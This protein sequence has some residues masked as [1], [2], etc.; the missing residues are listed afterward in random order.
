MNDLLNDIIGYI[1]LFGIIGSYI[2]QY[3]KIV[4]KKS[5]NGIS[6]KFLFIGYIGSIASFNNA[7]IFYFPEWKECHGFWDCDTRTLGFSQLLFQCICFFI[8]Y[9][10][11]MLYF[12]DIEL[13]ICEP[14]G[15]CCS[16]KLVAWIL[17]LI[18]NLF[19]ISLSITTFEL[20]LHDLINI[21]T[22]NLY[23]DILSGIVI[24][25]ALIQYLP[26]IYKTYSE[27]FPG[28][29]SLI[30]LGIQCPGSFAWT[31][32]LAIQD[33][34]NISTW[35]PYLVTA[36]LQLILL[37]LATFY[38]HKNKESRIKYEKLIATFN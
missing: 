30:T 23:A 15:P 29:L 25:A 17:F 28:S 37:I 19:L 6:D 2:P 38:Y 12:S 33:G 32:F 22:L 20:T 24:G 7:F 26:Q 11:F 27:K 9:L 1:I 31:I 10:L 18:S 35:L 34:S 36:T 21:R 13:S 4:R 16:K 5:S 3:I 8:F 14:C